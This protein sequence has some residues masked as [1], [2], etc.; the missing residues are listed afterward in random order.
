LSKDIY[1]KSKGFSFIR[2]KQIAAS[3]KG[4]F[5]TGPHYLIDGGIGVELGG[6]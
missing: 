6:R 3:T 4:S 1:F 2:I 5:M